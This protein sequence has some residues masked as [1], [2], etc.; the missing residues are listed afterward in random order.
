MAIPEGTDG[1]RATVRLMHDLIDQ[2]K[3]SVRIRQLA[4]EITRGLKQKDWVA[5]ISAIHSFVRDRIR[6]VRDIHGVETLHT[7]ERILDNAAGDCDD[8]TIL[9]C[10]L[11]ESLGY[12]TR[13]VAIGFRKGSF[14][15]VYPEVLIN[16]HWITAE[17]TEPVKFG[18][19]PKN[20]VNSIILEN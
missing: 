4:V 18:W 9:F 5:E 6:Y 19:K 14:S 11:A 20:I 12:H 16:E 3:K 17:T 7:A 8:K 2:G 13:I 1:V 15:H 10:A